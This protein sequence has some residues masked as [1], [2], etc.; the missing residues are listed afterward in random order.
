MTVLKTCMATVSL[1]GSLDEKLD[2]IAAAGFEGVEL[3]DEDLCESRLTPAECAKRCADLGLTIDLYQPFRRAEGV[4]AEEFVAVQERFRRHLGVM[5]QLGV[6]SI[7]VVSNTDQDAD[8]SR[9]CSV[10]QL[11]A[12]ADVAAEHGIT[13]CFEALAWGTHISRVADAWDAVRT[14]AHPN[15]TLVVDTFHLLAG[16]EDAAVLEALPPG[17]VAFLQL[18]DA[19]WLATD[20]LSWSRGHRCFPGEGEMDLRT[21]VSAV[22]AGGYS[23]PLSLEIFNPG[24]RERSP[25]EVAL[26]GAVALE[27]FL[28]EL[29]DTSPAHPMSAPAPSAE[30]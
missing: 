30:S 24:Y 22:V 23:G 29:P 1:G 3:L 4:P 15:L 27:R 16:G 14:A 6:C 12:L 19:P 7:L 10:T 9:D 18:A 11:A 28:D 20:Y 26:Q 17:A 13:I 25:H 21:P 8:P 5:A 2:A